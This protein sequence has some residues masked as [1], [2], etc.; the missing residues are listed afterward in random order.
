MSV[1]HRTESNKGYILKTFGF[2]WPTV[3]QLKTTVG[4]GAGLRKRNI[5][6]FL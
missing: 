6:T 1:T 3:F 5:S 2:D 4:I